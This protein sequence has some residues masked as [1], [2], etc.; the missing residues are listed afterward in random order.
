MSGPKLKTTTKTSNYNNNNNNMEPLLFTGVV[1]ATVPAAQPDVSDAGLCLPKRRQDATPVSSASLSLSSSSSSCFLPHHWHGPAVPDLASK[2]HMGD[3]VGNA[4]CDPKVEDGPS[5]PGSPELSDP[6][7]RPLQTSHFVSVSDIL[8]R[9]DASTNQVAGRPTG[10]AAL[11]QQ[12][13]RRQQQHHQPQQQQYSPL[14]GNPARPSSSAVVLGLRDPAKTPLPPVTQARSKT[15]WRKHTDPHSD[16]GQPPEHYQL[17][18]IAEQE[19]EGRFR[20][21]LRRVARGSS[22]IMRGTRCCVERCCGPIKSW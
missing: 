4:R 12:Q 18:G 6:V 20:N 10:H 21:L 15:A 9:D 13:Q 17:H 11:A 16:T 5:L 7:V 14:V 1:T 8:A 19:E 22:L 2:Q 3:A